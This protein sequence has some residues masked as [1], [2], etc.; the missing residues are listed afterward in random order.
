M[1][2]SGAMALSDL[3]VDRGRDRVRCGVECVAEL[4]L[5]ERVRVTHRVQEPELPR[6]TGEV[7]GPS[8]PATAVPVVWPLR[9][10]KLAEPDTVALAHTQAHREN[11]TRRSLPRQA[12]CAGTQPS[13]MGTTRT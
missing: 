8:G 11:V 3:D 4:V 6:W 2:C 7:P 1:N 9:T 13:G 12:R 5:D 10:G